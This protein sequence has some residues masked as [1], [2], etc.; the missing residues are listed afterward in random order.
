M[1]SAIDTTVAFAWLVA[2]SDY[3]RLATGSHSKFEAP[4]QV[5]SM[6][7]LELELDSAGSDQVSCKE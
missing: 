4:R 1:L 6:L 3:R 2:A 5:V 7:E